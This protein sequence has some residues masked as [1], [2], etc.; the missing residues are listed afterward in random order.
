MR[1]VAMIAALVLMT[2]PGVAFAQPLAGRGRVVFPNAGAPPIGTG[3][4]P[5][6]FIAGTA[7]ADGR[8]VLLRQ[9]T[10]RASVPGA[11]LE[12]YRLLADGRLD[13]HFGAAGIATVRLPAVPSGVA[14]QLDSRRGLQVLD[15]GGGR[16][17]VAA[18]V[19][20]EIASAAPPLVL[21][22]LTERGALDPAFGGDGFAETGVSNGSGEGRPAAVMADG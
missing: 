14:P 6:G 12:L 16:V 21:I 19:H 11:E 10:V 22:A 4:V 8:L 2:T 15:R 1:V 13:P 7:L 17:L 9:V 20:S 18:A 5:S 3:R